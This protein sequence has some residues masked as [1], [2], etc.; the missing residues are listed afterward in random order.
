[1][2]MKRNHFTLIPNFFIIVIV[3]FLITNCASSNGLI[4][5]ITVDEDIVHSTKR[6]EFEYTTRDY[7]NRTPLINRTQTLVKS[8]KENGEYIINVY[9]KLT[10]RAGDFRL[11]DSVYMIISNR[12]YP[13]T[14]KLFEYETYKNKSASTKKIS[15]GDDDE[16]TVVTGYRED[17]RDIVRINYQLSDT[18]ISAVKTAD[19]VSFRYYAGPSM[20]TIDVKDGELDA[21]KEVIRRD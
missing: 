20:I 19:T 5:R 17:N 7:D 10:L 14:S 15:T 12:V 16:V 3:G 2:N 4:D 1:M 9:D 8:I 13:V 6:V 21:V 18:M 11:E